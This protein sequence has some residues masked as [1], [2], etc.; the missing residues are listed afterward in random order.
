MLAH[1]QITV[2]HWTLADQNLL[3]LDEVP[4][5]FGHYFPI[6]FFL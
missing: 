6:I 5:V 4:P 1:L 2:G 3:V